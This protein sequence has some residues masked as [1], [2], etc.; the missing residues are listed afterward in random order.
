MK[1]QIENCIDASTC[2]KRVT[3]CAILDADNRVI[4]ME[5]NR[6]SPPG[7]VCVRVGVSGTQAAYPKDSTCQ[8]DHAEQR[9][10]LAVP[11]GSRPARAILYGHDFACDTCIA[12]LASIGIHDL[13]V[14]PDFYGTGVR[15]V[16]MA[17]PKP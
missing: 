17:T 9:A 13:Q 2:R 15:D 4:S 8:W 10:V 14:I 16:L 11:A 5:S 1:T 3:V 7:G 6:C 12:A